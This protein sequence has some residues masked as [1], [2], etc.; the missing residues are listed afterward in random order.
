[1]ADAPGDDHLASA[2]RTVR[3]MPPDCLAGWR[4]ALAR[5]LN[6]HAGMTVL[7]VGAGTGVF[8]TALVDWFGVEVLAIEPSAAMRAQIPTHPGVRILDG[9]AECLPVPDTSADGA[10]LS[11]VTHHAV[12]LPAT[13]GELRRTL[14]PG[15][16]VLIREVFPERSDRRPLVRFFPETRRKIDTYPTLEQTCRA[17]AAAGFDQIALEAV[18]QP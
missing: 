1:M 15:A 5:H 12:D 14:R 16:R 17:F 3:E 2:C 6:P 9:R 10:W 18:T 13:A 4:E 8:A 11:R 7:D